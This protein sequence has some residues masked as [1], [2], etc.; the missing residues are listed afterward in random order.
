MVL[1]WLITDDLANSPNF[2]R[3]IKFLLYTNSESL[4]PDSRIT[5]TATV[6]PLDSWSHQ[7]DLELWRAPWWWGQWVITVIS[8]STECKVSLNICSYNT[9]LSRPIINSIINPVLWLFLATL[10]W[11]DPIFMQGHYHLHWPALH[12]GPLVLKV[13]M[14]SEQSRGWPC[15]ISS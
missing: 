8:A 14:C 1:V 2:P 11:P 7:C 9:L 15:K 6:N 12:M 10:V 3:A 4:I 13:I 5:L